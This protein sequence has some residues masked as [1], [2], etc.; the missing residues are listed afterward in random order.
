MAGEG[1]GMTEKP[2]DAADVVWGEED[3]GV[4]ILDLGKDGIRDI[5]SLPKYYCQNCGK[6]I[7]LNLSNYEFREMMLKEP[8]Q[9]KKLLGKWRLRAEQDNINLY[10]PEC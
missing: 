2:I 6:S 7:E 5:T 1:E 9:L 10:C 3:A 8:E 4:T